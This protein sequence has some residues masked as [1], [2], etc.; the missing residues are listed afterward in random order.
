MKPTPES[1]RFHPSKLSPAEREAARARWKAL[2]EGD[3]PLVNDGWFGGAALMRADT[4]G[5][6]EVTE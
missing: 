3:R 2:T 4:L 1:R 6:P 5:R